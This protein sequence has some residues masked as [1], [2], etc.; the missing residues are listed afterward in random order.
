MCVGKKKTGRQLTDK[1][2]LEVMKVRAATHP[3]SR[4]DASLLLPV[5][6]PDTTLLWRRG[7]FNPFNIAYPARYIQIL[8]HPTLWDPLFI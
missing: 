5:G 1:D 3:F 8:P 2:Q 6:N 7:S 4:L